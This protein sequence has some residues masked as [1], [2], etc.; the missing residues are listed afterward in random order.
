MNFPAAN[1]CAIWG[2]AAVP[3]KDFA[4]VRFIAR[5]SPRAGGKYA[6]TVEAYFSFRGADDALKIALTHKIVDDNMFGQVSVIK[7]ATLASLK[8]WRLPLPHERAERLLKCL[9]S[10]SRHIGQELRFILPTTRLGDRDPTDEVF[11]VLL[12]HTD[13]MNLEELQLLRQHL[14][15]N[16]WV[17]DNIAE[18][19][20]PVWNDA[21]ICVQ[22]KGYAYLSE[23]NRQTDGAQAFVA[24]WFD[25]SMRDVYD[26][27]IEPAIR[28]AGYRA[29]RIDNKEHNN[30]I[31]D[32]IVSEIRRSRFIVADFTSEK[33]KPRG[34][35]YFEAGFAKG[36]GITVIW[37][38][39]E[40]LIGQ[41]HFDTRQFNHIVWQTAD[42]LREKLTHRITATLGDGPLIKNEQQQ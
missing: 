30:K 38:C 2:T 8:G 19:G 25:D 16:G 42:D 39:R 13:S 22:P 36:R 4:Q 34:G 24:M 32:E 9:I 26:N 41:V 17:H 33:D 1:Q 11:G 20:R 23:L 15:I 37:T 29:L 7:E 27:G 12:A 18:D 21:R 5:D 14:Q 40:D 6:I 28:A 3:L 31:D 10:L 35:V